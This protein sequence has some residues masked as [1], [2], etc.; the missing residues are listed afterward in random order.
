MA[1]IDGWYIINDAELTDGW[2]KVSL[3]NALT[4]IPKHYDD[5]KPRPEPMVS[6]RYDNGDHYI[7]W[8]FGV[9]NF[10]VCD[11]VS[12]SYK[13]MY[14]T[15][16]V[17]PYHEKAAKGQAEFID[18]LYKALIKEDGPVLGLASTGSGKTVSSLAV[19]CKLNMAVLVVVPTIKLANQWIESGKTHLGLSDRDVTIVRGDKCDYRGKSLIVLST[20]SGAFREYSDEFY[21]YCGFVVFDEADTVVSQRMFKLLGKLKCRYM[22]SVTARME[23]KDRRSDVMSLWI[24][25]TVRSDMIPMAIIVTPIRITYKRKKVSNANRQASIYN[26]ARN[27]KRNAYIVNILEWL[28]NKGRRVLVLGDSIK[29]LQLIESKMIKSGINGNRIGF[30]VGEK[31]TFKYR[32]I[33]NLKSSFN[34]RTKIEVKKRIEQYLDGKGIDVKVHKNKILLSGYAGKSSSPVID[35]MAYLK[36]VDSVSTLTTKHIMETVSDDE[37][38]RVIDGKGIDLVLASNGSMKMGIS[39]DWLDTLVDATPRS[40][41]V[42]PPGRVR[43][44]SKGKKTPRFY[45]LVDM[46]Y[47]NSLR[48]ISEARLREIATVGGVMVTESINVEL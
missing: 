11:V 40:D 34:D 45:T 43:R 21:K 47:S 32:F 5:G 9:R 19:A 20:K 16:T 35:L 23:R 28:I 7:P 30:I 3:K 38:N 25:N 29:Q 2:D 12:R 17:D 8:G 33:V 15:K 4:V 22:L 13:E 26:I 10:G 27:K 36:M 39:V 44:F 42:Q 14:N 24:N 31:Y 1:K 48:A 18:D 46:N 41:G 6:Y 37:I